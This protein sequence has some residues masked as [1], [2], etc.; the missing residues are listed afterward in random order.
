MQRVL[1][2]FEKLDRYEQRAAVRRNQAI[3]QIARL[4]VKW[5][6]NGAVTTLAL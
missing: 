5:L 4:N 6:S 3:R 1:P 2:G